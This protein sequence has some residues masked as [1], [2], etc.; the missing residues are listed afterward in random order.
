MFD[1][2]HLIKTVRNN[3][4]KHNF[5]KE[6]G[7]EISWKYIED[8]Y[9]HDKKY[10]L[11]AAPKL[12]D[13]HIFTNNFEKMKVKFASQV[14][15]QTVASGLNLYI[16]FGVIPASAVS[17]AE[18]VEMMNKLFDLLNSSHT[19][20][21]KKFNRAFKK[22]EYQISFL[23]ECFDFF[24]KLRVIDKSGKDVTS[25]I[26]FLKCFNV[27]ING[28][29]HLWGSWLSEKFDYVFTRRLNQDCLEIFF[30]KLRQQSGKVYQPNRNSVPEII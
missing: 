9:N 3:L 25:R 29:I 30:G 10:S 4:R 15:S 22:E 1:T 26:K 2:T 5:L 20:S 7:N 19:S 14:F 12:T 27:T 11:R 28:L 13:S 24:S 21:A 16:R 8:F 23:R 6:N 18:F 17:T